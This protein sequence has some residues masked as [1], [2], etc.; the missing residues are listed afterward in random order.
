[1]SVEKTGPQK[2]STRAKLGWRRDTTDTQTRHEDVA[3]RQSR[4]TL[5]MRKRGRSSKA[6]TVTRITT[7]TRSVTLTCE[8]PKATTV[9]RITTP[10][11]HAAQ[12]CQNSAQTWHSAMCRHTGLG[13]LH[14]CMP[15]HLAASCAPGCEKRLLPVT[16]EARCAA[17]RESYFVPVLKPQPLLDSIG[18]AHPQSHCPA[19][20]IRGISYPYAQ[21][22]R[23]C[24]G[25]KG[26]FS[27]PTLG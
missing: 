23:N 17:R 10:R 8:A 1:M 27:W 14:H 6:R 3:Q 4:G 15:Q 5:D 26:L 24:C 21:A 19:T 13:N 16:P 22:M 7:P 25:R 11:R 9:T 2:C 20:A 18:K 12:K